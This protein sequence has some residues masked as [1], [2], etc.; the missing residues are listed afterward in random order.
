MRELAFLD[1]D[2]SF[3]PQR[4]NICEYNFKEAFERS[5]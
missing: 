3:G 4:H 1:V 2:D 5:D